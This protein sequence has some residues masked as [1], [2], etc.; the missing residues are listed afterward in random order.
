MHVIPI[1]THQVPS[2]SR[3]QVHAI[4]FELRATRTV[5]HPGNIPAPTAPAP[6]FA[7]LYPNCSAQL[8]ASTLTPS[9][10]SSSDRVLTSFA[11]NWVGRS[12]SNQKQFPLSRLLARN[13]HLPRVVIRRAWRIVHSS[14]SYRFDEC[15]ADWRGQHHQRIRLTR[16]TEIGRTNIGGPAPRG[17]GRL[18]S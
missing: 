17:T 5:T 16:A 9:L 7:R 18:D 13:N 4:F 1:P 10:R 11:Q 15:K 8:L 6:S 14:R 12:E 2:N 3:R